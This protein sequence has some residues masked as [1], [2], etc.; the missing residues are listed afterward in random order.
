[1]KNKFLITRKNLC[2][3]LH[4]ETSNIE[5]NTILSNLSI[6]KN[7]ITKNKHDEFVQ[8]I[9]KDKIYFSMYKAEY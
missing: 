4:Y 1:M 6:G 8:V 5:L 2:K 7:C 9:T 3:Q